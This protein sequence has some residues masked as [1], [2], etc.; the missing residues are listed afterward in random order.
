M[1]ITLIQWAETQKS[2][3]FR[4]CFVKRWTAK[5][6]VYYFFLVLTNF[7]SWKYHWSMVQV[8]HCTLKPRVSSVW[9]FQ[10]HSQVMSMGWLTGAT[11][12][13]QQNSSIRVTLFR[14]SK[15]FHLSEWREWFGE[16]DFSFS[17][18]F[19]TANSL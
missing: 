13:L 19:E 17:F 2:Q 1:W 4:N 9:R 3:I 18:L 5:N 7:P 11:Y 8:S 6:T 15:V 16:K 10:F 12:K 14:H